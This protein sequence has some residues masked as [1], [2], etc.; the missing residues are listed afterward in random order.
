VN[1]FLKTTSFLYKH[2]LDIL[3]PEVCIGCGSKDSALCTTCIQNLKRAPFIEEPLKACFSY[4]DP[5]IKKALWKLKY[6]ARSSLGEQLGIL[7]Y[8]EYL[9]EISDL[10]LFSPGLPVIVVPIPLSGKRLKERHY[11]QSEKIAQG[12]VKNHKEFLQL[13]TDI[14]QKNKETTPQ[15]TIKNKTRRL[16]NIAGV[17]TLTKKVSI[18]GRT[19]IVIDDITTTGATLRE[20]VKLLKDHGAKKVIGFAVAH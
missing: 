6:Y 11:N 8:Q 20:A 7:L 4:H 12:F 13:Q 15:A 10:R 14:L 3:F 5:V 1:R 18:A 17:F 16:K 19:I 2:L 9:E